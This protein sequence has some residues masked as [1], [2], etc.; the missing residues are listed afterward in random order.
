MHPVQ[1]YK[2]D[3]V[4][5]TADLHLGHRNILKFTDRR[6][7]MSESERAVMASGDT[8]EIGNLRISNET[9]SRMNEE[10][11]RRWNA[12]VPPDGEVYVIG[13]FA[14]CKDIRQAQAWLKRLNGTVYLIWGNHDPR[15]IAS[16]FRKCWE[17]LMI[18]VMDQPI[19]LSHYAHRNWPA[20]HHGAWHLYGHD[21]ARLPQLNNFSMDAGVDNQDAGYAPFSFRDLQAYFRKH[22]KGKGIDAQL[23]E[24]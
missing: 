10:L 17:V 4:F 14:M 21:H 22:V 7:F 3:N 16:A 18:E 2:H 20:S 19:W 8:K 15:H 13:D 12:K 5:F 23:R 9:L 24:D 11:V 6:E 1:Q